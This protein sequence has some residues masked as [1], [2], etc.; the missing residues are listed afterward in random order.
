MRRSPDGCLPTRRS[1]LKGLGVGVVSLMA[2]VQGSTDRVR[3]NRRSAMS[4]ATTIYRSVGGPPPE[5]LAKVL[6]LL[7]G[8]AN[9][10]GDHNV[11]VIKPNLQWWNQGAPN[12]A[13]TAALIDMIM[14]RPGGFNGEV[15]IGENN[16]R[17]ITPWKSAG[18]ST[19]FV[20]NSDLP[21]IRNYNELAEAMKK[22]YGDR[23]SVCHWIDVGVGGKRIFGPQ[24]GSGY[25]Y[26]DGT[27]GV[28]F[29]SMDNGLQ[30]KLRRSVI[31]SYPIFKSNQGTIVDLKNGVWENGAYTQQAV[32]FI[33]LSAVNHHSGYCGITSAVKNYF[34]VTD[35]SH[36][37]DPAKG[38]KLSGDH[39]NFHAFAFNEWAKGPVPGMMGAEIGMFLRT[40]RRADLNIATAEWV[41]LSSRTD[42]PIAH[43]KTVLASTDPVALDFHSAKYLVYPNSKCGKHKPEDTGG[44]L[45]QYLAKCAEHGGCT[46]DEAHV[47]VVSYDLAKGRAQ[48]D[49]ELPV[50]GD[51]DWGTDPK[52][53][54]KYG[55]F[56]FADGLV[57]G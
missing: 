3:P 24:D 49:Q 52:A 51:I 19:P 21:S 46:L 1:I 6:D 25:V 10:V 32:K 13:A 9:L 22:K 8:V 44:P 37:A 57:G 48:T 7:G 23:F 26:C 31:M 36:G 12:I 28:P 4:S 27:G 11:V 45:N 17:G 42:P 20:R 56:R 53:L 15:I 35:I 18:W 33:N 14:E 43:T 40:V 41:G 47:R 38:G 50:I 2:P 29:L 34:G 39:C 5:N 16:H 55:V 30:G 54:L